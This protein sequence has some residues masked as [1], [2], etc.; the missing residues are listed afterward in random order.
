MT[1]LSMSK[2]GFSRLDVLLRA[3]SFRWRA[4]VAAGLPAPL[5]ARPTPHE[6][7]GQD[8]CH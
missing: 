1:V 3:Q 7:D 5:V 2:K 4:P 8:H 6:Q